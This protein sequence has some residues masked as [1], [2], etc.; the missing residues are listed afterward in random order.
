MPSALS[1]S[2]TITSVLKNPIIAPYGCSRNPINKVTIPNK[3]RRLINKIT[4]VVIRLSK[5]DNFADSK[6]CMH[7]TEYLKN[8]G[9]KKVYYSNE[10]GELQFERCQNMVNEHI[11]T[12]GKKL[13]YLQT[14]RMMLGLSIR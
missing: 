3:L 8:L 9:I 13:T 11:S 12:I 10:E 14:K 4:L 2:C 6:P 5:T 1:S 7:C